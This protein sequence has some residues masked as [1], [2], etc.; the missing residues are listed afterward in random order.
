MWKESIGSIADA[1]DTPSK[2]TFD[3]KS[4]IDSLLQYSVAN[5]YSIQNTMIDFTPAG[6]K[7]IYSSSRRV[8]LK[9]CLRR[10]LRFHFLRYPYHSAARL[11]VPFTGSG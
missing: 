7:R 4:Q 10:C 3:E 11:S 9:L 6:T 2:R 5:G 8:F 1:D